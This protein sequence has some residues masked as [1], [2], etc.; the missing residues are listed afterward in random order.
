M[1]VEFDGQKLGAAGGPTLLE[2]TGAAAAD[3]RYMI[4]FT[5]GANRITVVESGG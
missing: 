2:T 4:E 3:D 1:G 5:G